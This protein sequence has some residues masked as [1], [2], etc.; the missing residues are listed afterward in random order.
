MLFDLIYLDHLSLPH[1]SIEQMYIA[2]SFNILI[3]AISSYDKTQGLP[4]NFQLTVVAPVNL[5]GFLE[6]AA[7]DTFFHPEIIATTI[8]SYARSLGFKAQ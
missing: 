4:V 3:T 8:A 5:L 6:T 1:N 2:S 7:A